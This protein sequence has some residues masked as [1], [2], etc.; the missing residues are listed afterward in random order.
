MIV[1][2]MKSETRQ[3]DIILENMLSHAIIKVRKR[4]RK[5]KDAT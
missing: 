3:C 4:T 1:L 5:T 2:A